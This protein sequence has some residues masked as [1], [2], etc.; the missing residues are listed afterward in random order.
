MGGRSCGRHDQHIPWLADGHRRVDHQVVAGVVERCHG[1]AAR[2]LA[3]C[4]RPNLGLHEPTSPV[5]FMDSRHIEFSQRG[6]E[7]GWRS[8]DRRDYAWS[9]HG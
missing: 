8:L 1:R 6:D 4:D 3:L 2:P 5:R 9:V 7:I